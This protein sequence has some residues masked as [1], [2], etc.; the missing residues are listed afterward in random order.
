MK[1]HEP[2]PITVK[3][4]AVSP[5]IGSLIP[6][7]RYVTSGSAGMDLAACLEEPT[8]LAPGERRLIPTGL[9]LQ[10]PGPHVG[11]FVFARSGLA[12]KH[13]IHLANGV[14][15]IDSD[16]TGEILCALVNGGDSPF[17][18]RPGDRIAQLVFLPV[19]AARL[20]PVESLDPTER[21][22]GGF[23]HTGL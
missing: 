19:F 4:K 18:I 7:P 5:L 13:G 22:E 14:G 6:W 1:A 15:V 16:Y 23:G 11:A 10:L 8:L 12:S 2:G 17:E 21:G 20:V 9:A 3:V